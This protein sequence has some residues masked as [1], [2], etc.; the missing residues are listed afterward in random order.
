MTTHGGRKVALVLMK[1]DEADATIAHLRER[2][3]QIHVEDHLTYF[4]V[5][6][7]RELTIELP[8]VAAFL[9]RALTMDSFL[10]TLSAYF[11]EIHVDDSVL[12]ISPVA[13]A[14]GDGV[15]R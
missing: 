3:P 4:R 8:E 1:S 15:R 11:G 2:S 9:G 7:D 14:E 5:E 12:R 13:A 6:N 10:V